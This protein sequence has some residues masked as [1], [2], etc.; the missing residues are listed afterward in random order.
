[1]AV[2]MLVSCQWEELNSWLT[3]KGQGVFSIDEE[4]VFPADVTE[5]TLA[6]RCDAEW[7]VSLTTEAAW[8]RI[9]SVDKEED[10]GSVVIGM[11]FNLT[12]EERS[13]E[14]SFAAGGQQRVTLIR[15]QGISSMLD[16]A[17]LHFVEADSRTLQLTMHAPW[18]A[19]ISDGADWYRIE[20]SSGAAGTSRMT[21]TVP[22][23][24]VDKGARSSAIRFT[25][26]GKSFDLPVVQGQKD[27][28]MLDTE[29]REY[30]FS[31][32][33]GMLE[34]GTRTNVGQP[35]VKVDYDGAS[36]GGWID[37]LST[38]AL[39]EHVHS[40][41]ISA[42]ETGRTRRADIVFLFETDDALLSDTLTLVQRN[43][44][45]LL[46]NNVIGAYGLSGG[47]RLYRSGKNLL[48]RL[49]SADKS[50]TALR[51]IDPAE[52]T[53]VEFGGIPADGTLDDRFSLSF[54]FLQRGEV[55]ESGIYSVSVIGTGSDAT[56]DWLWLRAE[57]GPGFIVKK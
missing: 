11:D 35:S 42:N 20:P 39:D 53:V 31:P 51:I 15:Q 3:G 32:E 44:D 40:F 33:G 23:A 38:R 48:S 1:M 2:V 6:L 36:A 7:T 56:A 45:P 50:S 30:A 22:E 5:A 47:D 10:G 28:L 55:L 16:Q 52:L 54:R 43:L 27:V 29:E 19:R 26:G 8:L 49:Y 9:L 37:H 14:L 4:F 57:E 25:V 12:D 34:I 18:E 21:V 46:R 41:S 24:Y 17:S 13:A